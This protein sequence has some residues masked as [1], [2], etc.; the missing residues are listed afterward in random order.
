MYPAI[1]PNSTL[2]SRNNT[3][4]LAW[5]VRMCERFVARESGCCACMQCP[6]LVGTDADCVFIYRPTCGYDFTPL[7]WRYCRPPRDRTESPLCGRCSKRCYS[8]DN[9]D[10]PNFCRIEDSALDLGIR[11]SRMFGELFQRFGKDS[12]KL[13][14]C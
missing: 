3:V 1:Y 14:C 5:T 2:T 13:H 6:H 8:V 9:S 4:A 7:R 11:Q 12:P 10:G